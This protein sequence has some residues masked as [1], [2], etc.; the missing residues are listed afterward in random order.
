FQCDHQRR[1]DIVAVVAAS[2][3]I[4]LEMRAVIRA[5]AAAQAAEHVLEHVLE[6]AAAT[7]AAARPGAGAVLRPKT[8]RLKRAFAAKP[9]SARS[10]S[11]AKSVKALEA[12][13]AFGVDLAAV[14]SFALSRITDDFVGRIELGKARGRLRIVLIGVR[15]QFLGKLAEGALDHRRART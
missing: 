6:A 14:K 10:R 8:E 7:G 2:G 4:R 1:G 11:S 15:M 12:R 3:E 5:R 9:A 13:L